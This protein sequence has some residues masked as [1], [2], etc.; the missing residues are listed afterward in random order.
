MEECDQSL[1]AD[2]P[3]DCKKL[4]VS[5][6]AINSE[7]TQS[8]NRDHVLQ[9]LKEL[10]CMYGS[11]YSNLLVHGRSRL[12]VVYQEQEQRVLSR[13]GPPAI[14]VDKIGS[15]RDVP[16][17]TELRSSDTEQEKRTRQDNGQCI[18]S[19]NHNMHI[20]SDGV[21]GCSASSP[22]KNSLVPLV[23]Q[24]GLRHRIMGNFSWKTAPKE[25]V[26]MRKGIDKPVPQIGI[27]QG[28]NVEPW[29]NLPNTEM[30]F[31]ME[32]HPCFAKNEQ[33]LTTDQ[34]GHTSV[35]VKVGMS[36]QESHEK[37]GRAPC[38]QPDSVTQGN[39]ETID[40]S[41]LPVCSKAFRHDSE[42]GAS[43]FQVPGQY[44]S[45]PSGYQA[46]GK[47]DFELNNGQLA[48][49]KSSDMTNDQ[50]LSSIPSTKRCSYGNRSRN[51]SHFCHICSRRDKESSHAVC[52]NLYSTGCRKVVCQPCCNLY[53]YSDPRTTFSRALRTW[54]CI[55]CRGK[56]P[57]R[58]QCHRYTQSHRRPRVHRLMNGSK[59]RSQGTLTTVPMKSREHYRRQN[60][61]VMGTLACPITGRASNGKRS[62]H[63]NMQ[64][65]LTMH[66][67]EK[68]GQRDATAFQDYCHDSSEKSLANF[69]QNESIKEKSNT[70][71]DHYSS[72][73]AHV[74][75]EA[76]PSSQEPVHGDGLPW[77][78]KH[79]NLILGNKKNDTILSEK[80]EETYE[81]QSMN[82]FFDKSEKAGNNDEFK[83]LTQKNPNDESEDVD[84]EKPAISS[85]VVGLEKHQPVFQD[86]PA[87]DNSHNIPEASIMHPVE[88]SMAIQVSSQDVPAPDNSCPAAQSKLQV[89][90]QSVH[91]D[92]KPPNV[93]VNCQ[94]V[95][96]NAE[97][98]DHILKTVGVLESRPFSTPKTEN[99]ILSEG[100]L[101][102][103]MSGKRNKEDRNDH[104]K[105]EG[106]S[107]GKGSCGE[108]FDHSSEAL[109]AGQ[110]QPDS[111]HATSGWPWNGLWTEASLGVLCL[112]EVAISSGPDE[113]G[114]AVIETNE[115]DG[116]V[117][118]YKQHDECFADE[119]KCDDPISAAD[120]NFSLG[121]LPYGSL[122][123]ESSG[124]DD[125]GSDVD[126]YLN[127]SDED[128]Q[129][130]TDD[131]QT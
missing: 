37:V 13:K 56:C 78:E 87:I 80:M 122:G 125:A 70:I 38:L 30:G 39:I 74:H 106:N 95:S 103:D 66:W 128:E 131:V 113:S 51:P 92:E 120:I 19:K 76:L 2:K 15:P 23:N 32:R 71:N 7:N 110:E 45:N 48:I 57:P 97:E 112:H 119:W 60:K 108:A 82:L 21:F 62:S 36:T 121:Q 115:L 93:A 129:N 130:D 89:D 124:H 42:D 90:S 114:N 54:E 126:K 33:P 68:E 109:Q 72:R 86:I 94:S 16:L 81:T 22:V 123:T 58:A 61:N 20:T 53:G 34:E 98:D 29:S 43:Y 10:R 35:M 75:E 59:V 40:V 116:D 69:D 101:T 105:F 100:K 107:D 1:L 85:S 102:A 9:S 104:W 64:S 52:S 63:L 79:S 49:E 118:G 18:V 46:E 111:S 12:P 83:L 67:H 14:W 3:D 41:S 50:P 117:L 6:E 88:G 27:I 77:Q 4:H 11:R 17:Q 55:H 31:D 84:C 25:E 65:I 5:L 99:S 47:K 91:M 8:K 73:A 44:P 127:F 28:I 96:R 24:S 26:F